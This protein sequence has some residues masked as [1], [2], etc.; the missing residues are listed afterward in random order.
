VL[1]TLG[2]LQPSNQVVNLV[3]HG[4]QPNKSITQ[5]CSPKGVFVGMTMCQC[6]NAANMPLLL[7]PQAALRRLPG[8][9]AQ[10]VSA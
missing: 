6:T 7:H 9:S 3:R 2:S 10:Q 5:A 1:T 8:I 4:N